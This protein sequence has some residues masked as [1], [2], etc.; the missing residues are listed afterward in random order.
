MKINNCLTLFVLVI[1]SSSCSIQGLFSDY[2][3]VNKEYP[4]LLKEVSHNKMICQIPC[5]DSCKML[6]LKGKELSTCLEVETKTILYLW[7]SHCSSPYCY[8]LDRVQAYC[9][10]KGN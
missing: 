8:D 1:M 5:S 10:E 4:T 7:S 6:V 9:K 2:K 3:K